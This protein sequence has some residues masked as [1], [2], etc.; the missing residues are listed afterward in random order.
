MLFAFFL[1][2]RIVRC[3]CINIALTNWAS[4]KDSSVAHAP[5]GRFVYHI[6]AFHVSPV[7]DLIS[8]LNW[9]DSAS[10]KLQHGGYLFDNKMMTQILVKTRKHI[11]KRS[12]L[13]T[14]GKGDFIRFKLQNKQSQLSVHKLRWP[15]T[16]VWF[17]DL[18]FWS[19]GS[20]AFLEEIPAKWKV[21]MSNTDVSLFVH[22][23]MRIW[24]SFSIINCLEFPSPV[25]IDSISMRMSWW[26]MYF[27]RW[28]CL[29]S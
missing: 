22:N 20:S 15:Q 3:D 2:V 9:F 10:L 24:F 19:R 4:V 13:K 7:L 1:S 25:M 23:C 5:F 14:S 29:F 8:T 27:F 16:H 26:S 28:S 6:S 18:L 17:L 12:S 11:G 21:L